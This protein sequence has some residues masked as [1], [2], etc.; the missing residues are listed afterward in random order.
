M[1]PLAVGNL[2]PS[3]RAWS[4]QTSNALVDPIE[5]ERATID[6]CRQ[7]DVRAFERVYREHQNA[8]FGVALRMLERQ[9]D[10]EDAVQTTLIRL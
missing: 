8:L 6:A 9:E 7:G 10:G 3:R 1:N 5:E 2:A 4:L